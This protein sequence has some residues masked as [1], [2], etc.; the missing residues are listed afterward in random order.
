MRGSHRKCQAGICFK[1][2]HLLMFVFLL[3]LTPESVCYNILDFSP[4]GLPFME[5]FTFA[6]N[7]LLRQKY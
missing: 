6:S 1:K 5:I 2:S 3:L 4:C 7:N